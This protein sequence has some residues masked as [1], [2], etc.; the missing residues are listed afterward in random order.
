MKK[1][2]YGDKIVHTGP[3]SRILQFLAILG[4]SKSLHQT[5]LFE[6]GSKVADVPP[7][8]MVINK[9]NAV[10]DKEPG[11]FEEEGIIFEGK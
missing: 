7:E 5:Y 3:S 10:T 8:L 11:F 2:L 1:R 9:E 6:A 4:M